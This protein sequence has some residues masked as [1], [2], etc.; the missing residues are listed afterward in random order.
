M[1]LWKELDILRNNK[2]R[3]GSNLPMYQ[4]ASKE[5]EIIS[6]EVYFLEDTIYDKFRELWESKNVKISNTKSQK[7]LEEENLNNQFFSI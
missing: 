5:Y 7:I 6:E 2:I 3:L 4:Y 1:K